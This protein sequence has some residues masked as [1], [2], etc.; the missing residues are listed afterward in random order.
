MQIANR[1]Y[2]YMNFQN[3]K[4]SNITDIHSIML[5]KQVDLNQF[6][7]DL[8]DAISRAKLKKTVYWDSNKNIKFMYIILQMQFT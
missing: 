6:A 5:S 2:I 8:K 4:C 1:D 7:E 3:I